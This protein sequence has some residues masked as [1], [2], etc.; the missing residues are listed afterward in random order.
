[1]KQLIFL[2]M[3]IIMLSACGDRRNPKLEKYSDTWIKNEVKRCD[4]LASP[5]RIKALACSNYKRECSARNL[6]C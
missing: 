2:L 1:M 4:T 3:C 6:N 5:S